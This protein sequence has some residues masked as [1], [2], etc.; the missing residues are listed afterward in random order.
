MHSMVF[1]RCGRWAL[2]LALCGLAGC[3]TQKSLYAWN[4][5]QP[6]VYQ[7]LKEG[8]ESADGQILALEKG[9]ELAAAQNAQLPPGYY[10]HLGLLY[11][12][13]GHGDQAVAAWNREKD[14][15]P[16]SGQY[17]DYLMNNMK[18]NGS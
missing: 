7:Y 2:L 4:G 11:L 18:K 17:I 14:L 13:T 3:A 9:I 10:A 6:Q 12:N 8:G 5:Y 15:F 16:E 1:A